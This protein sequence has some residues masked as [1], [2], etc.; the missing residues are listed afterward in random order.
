MRKPWLTPSGVTPADPS[1]GA[2]ITEMRCSATEM[3]RAPI[4]YARRQNKW[5]EYTTH[6]TRY[7]GE[8]LGVTQS[9]ARTLFERGLAH[10]VGKPDFNKPYFLV[11]RVFVPPSS[12]RSRIGTG[13]VLFL[14]HPSVRSGGGADGLGRMRFTGFGHVDKNEKQ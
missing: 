9:L 1:Y 5:D 7:E 12:E 10:R 4:R 11:Y 3:C 8:N 2:V 6:I 13:G 14:S